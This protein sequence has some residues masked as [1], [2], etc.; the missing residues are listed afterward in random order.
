M[1]YP[2]L[3]ELREALRSF[4]SRPYTT[5][6]PRCQHRPFEKFRGKPEF[7]QEDC[8]GCGACAQV[9]PAGAITFRDEVKNGRARRVLTLRWDT[10]IA[11]GQCEAN[12]ITAKGII[13]SREFDLATTAKR[14]DL[15]QEIEKDIVLCE[16]CGAMIVP[17][18]QMQWVARRLGPLCFSNA[19]LVLF[20]LADQD[21]D[22]RPMVKQER[23]F[24]RADRIKILCP[25]C[26]R[27]AVLKS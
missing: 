9:C 12:C 18:E 5:R 27:K 6:F 2:K 16:G 22:P 23:E 4:F 14:E 8:V 20:Y 15:V 26:R 7:H 17:Q 21:T 13:L 10:C 3:R 25:R 11:C 24:L 19:S 1:R